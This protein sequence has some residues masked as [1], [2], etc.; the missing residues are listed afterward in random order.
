VKG[1][2]EFEAP[3]RVSYGLPT[4]A[5]DFTEQA[6]RQKAAR[7]VP[8]PEDDSLEVPTLSQLSGWTMDRLREALRDAGV[9]TSGSKSEICIRLHRHLSG[10]AQVK[11]GCSIATTAPAISGKVQPL[12]MSG[13]VKCGDCGQYGH[14]GGSDQCEQFTAVV[15]TR[16]A[17]SRAGSSRDVPLPKAKVTP[18]ITS[19]DEPKNGQ[20]PEKPD[21]LH[22]P[23]CR[24]RVVMRVNSIDNGRFYGCVNLTSMTRCK[25]T[26][27]IRRQ[28]EPPPDL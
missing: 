7:E 21:N 11:K 22:C 3:D 2:N 27:N 16:Q 4:S 10:Y 13:K 8:V 17:A 1:Y 15:G 14:E 26:I 25:G 18:P 23:K 12:K 9:Q 20:M 5:K 19:V 28:P 6:N 24:A